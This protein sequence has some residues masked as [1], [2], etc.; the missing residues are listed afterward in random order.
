[1]KKLKLSKVALYVL[2]FLVLVYSFFPIYWIIISPLRGNPGFFEQSTVLWPTNFDVTYFI[3]MWNTTNFPVYYKNSFIVAGSTTC[4]TII[5]STFIAYIL[6][7]F[8]FK[9]KNLLLNSMLVGYMLPPMLIAIPLLGIFISLGI[10]DTLIGLSLAHIA[11][12]LPFGV[13]MLNSFL[14]TVPFDL[15][16]SAWVDGASR[17]QALLLV[18]FPLLI[19]GVISVGVFSFIVSF[20]DYT[21][22]L[23]IVSSEGNKTI[24][25]G[26]AAIK[27]STS[28]Q[29][30]ELMAGAAMIIVPMVILFSFVTKY[31]IK[32]LTSGAV[33]G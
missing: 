4:I 31:F 28:L 30:S 29:Q 26:L 12:T 1:M 32:G 11:I 22:G 5:A 18:I 9:G 17:V 14:K 21:F 2:A 10:E 27:E 6:T 7:R 23:M 19:P 24:P 15:E 13:W 33:K 25:V 3:N 8:R 16:E 20:T